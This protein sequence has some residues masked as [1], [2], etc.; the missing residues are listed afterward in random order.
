MAVDIKGLFTGLIH[1]FEDPLAPIVFNNTYGAVDRLGR[2]MAR[3]TN[4]EA[5]QDI[6]TK[7][8]CFWNDKEIEKVC[9]KPE[10]IIALA[11]CL[12]QSL[13]EFTKRAKL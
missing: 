4:E 8:L 12:N 6:K 2:L 3:K 1:T 5:V 11:A 10:F 9:A 7:L 13:V